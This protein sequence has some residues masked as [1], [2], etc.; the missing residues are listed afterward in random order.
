MG[1]FIASSHA[2]WG[3]W[4]APNAAAP[5]GYGGYGRDDPSRDRNGYNDQYN[6]RSPQAD[7]ETALV[8]VLREA[9]VDVVIALLV[10]VIAPPTATM[11]VG[12]RGVKAQ[13]KTEAVIIVNEAHKIDIVGVI[14]QDVKSRR[15]LLQVQ[16]VLSSTIHFRLTTLRV[17]RTYFLQ[18]TK[19]ILIL[20]PVLSRTLFVGGVT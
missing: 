6:M 10:V 16:S 19:S 8:L 4:G 1:A 2:G 9:M 13:V 11:V 12:S 15:C 14:V 18:Q 3:R 7:I 20:E 17:G 5:S